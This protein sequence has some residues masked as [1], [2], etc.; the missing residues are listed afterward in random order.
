[1][2]APMALRILVAVALLLAA[3]GSEPERAA[4]ASPTP[5]PA[6]SLLPSPSPSPSPTDGGCT[7]ASVTGEFGV[8]ITERDFSFDPACLIMLGGQGLILRNRGSVAHNLTVQGTD[9]DLDLD[10][11]GINRTE[12]IGGVV[13][14]GTYTFFC[15]F[16]R[17]QGMEGEITVSAAG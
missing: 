9:V 6:P 15:K 1:M 8:P 4:P 7:D 11:G 12:A 10:P 5:V 14:P 17:A 13:A 16:H 2:L 3:C